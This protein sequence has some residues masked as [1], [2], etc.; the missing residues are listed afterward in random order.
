MFIIIITL[1]YGFS[2]LQFNAKE[3][4]RKHNLGYLCLSFWFSILLFA[5]WCAPLR[6]TEISTWYDACSSFFFSSRSL[7]CFIYTK[8]TYD[9]CVELSIIL[10]CEAI[11]M[12]LVLCIS[13]MAK[14]FLFL[15]HIS[16]DKLFRLARQV[17]FTL[18]DFNYMKSYLRT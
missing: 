5:W 6:Y 18:M 10:V 8:M 9:L 12:S 3:T 4:S 7:F 15:I 17:Y 1:F 14:M 11:G 2:N 13:S 16:Y